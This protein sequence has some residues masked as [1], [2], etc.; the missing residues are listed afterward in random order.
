MASAVISIAIEFRGSIAIGFSAFAP[1]CSS[2]AQE[3]A[4]IGKFFCQ[5]VAW[6]VSSACLR[7]CVGAIASICP[8]SPS[9]R[10]MVRGDCLGG[11]CSEIDGGDGQVEVVWLWT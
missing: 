11:I 10:L 9:S 7:G 2:S 3:V 5:A 1:L 6:V 4:D 8:Y